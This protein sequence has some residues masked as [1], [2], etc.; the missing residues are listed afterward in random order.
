MVDAEGCCV[1]N[2]QLYDSTGE[3]AASSDGVSPFPGGLRIDSVDGELLLDLPAEQN[4][5]MKYHLYNNRGQ[6]LTSSDGKTTTIGP[7]LRMDSPNRGPAAYRAP[8]QGSRNPI[9]A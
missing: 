3:P 8:P 6:L 7:C 2:Y 9:S 4:A 1:V 5:S